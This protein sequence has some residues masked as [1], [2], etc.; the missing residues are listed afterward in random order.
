MG[1][2]QHGS[3]LVGG[4]RFVKLLL[5]CFHVCRQ[6]AAQTSRTSAL[7]NL[8]LDAA[9]LCGSMLHNCDDAATAVVE[10]AGYH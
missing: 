1:S 10:G 7:A 4:A 3:H 5:L 9:T 2:T 8:P 6:A